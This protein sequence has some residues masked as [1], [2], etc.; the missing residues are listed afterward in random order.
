[1]RKSIIVIVKKRR[2]RDW[3]Y[4][5][6]DKHDEKIENENNQLEDYDDNMNYIGEEEL[7]KEDARKKFLENYDKNDKISNSFKNIE[8]E[9]KTKKH[10]GKRFK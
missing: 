2:S 4:D 8:E 1:M 10:K 5:D 6:Y 3:K 9:P 7:S